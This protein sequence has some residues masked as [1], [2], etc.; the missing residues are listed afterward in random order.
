MRAI[1][2]DL[3]KLN[4]DK[5]LAVMRSGEVLNHGSKERYTSLYTSTSP[6]GG[7]TWELPKAIY[8]YGYRPD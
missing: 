1:E 3:I 8:P 6:D 4:G 5:L 7:K 2:A